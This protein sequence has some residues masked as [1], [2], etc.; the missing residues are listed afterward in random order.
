M[1]SWYIDRSKNFLYDSLYNCLKLIYDISKGKDSLDVNVLI[2]EIKNHPEL[3]IAEG[4]INAAI[5][6]FRDHG[7]LS[8]QNIIGDSA[9]D[10][11]EEKDQIESEVSN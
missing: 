11:I 4:N 8:K 6:R 9:I 5:T 7:L 3:G 10:F 1:N 2:Q